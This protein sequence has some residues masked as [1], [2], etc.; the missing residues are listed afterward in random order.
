MPG[1]PSQGSNEPWFGQPRQSWQ[2]RGEPL[3]RFIGQPRTARTGKGGATYVAGA[4][5]DVWGDRLD[6][7]PIYAEN[8]LQERAL[9]YLNA[10]E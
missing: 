1:P 4:P 9:A 6:K 8:A 5:D 3:P 2:G 10:R 7:L